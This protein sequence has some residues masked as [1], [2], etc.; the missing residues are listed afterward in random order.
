MQHGRA[1]VVWSFLRSADS[2]YPVY[3]RPAWSSFH[4]ERERELRG[5][6]TESRM[7]KSRFAFSRWKCWE[8]FC[9]SSFQFCLT[10]P[11]DGARFTHVCSTLQALG[12]TCSSV[13]WGLPFAIW[14]FGKWKPGVWAPKLIC[15]CLGLSYEVN[16]ARTA[17]WCTVMQVCG[18]QT[19]FVPIAK[20]YLSTLQN[21]F[22]QIVKSICPN[23][24]MYLSQLPNVFAHSTVQHSDASSWCL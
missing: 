22:V 17:Q 14:P 1:S 15:Q 20:K 3:H 16:V 7:E 23:C 5:V 10:N 13:W 2:V 4:L 19:V 6:T 24:K 21:V 8:A 18:L 11:L 12:V 9:L